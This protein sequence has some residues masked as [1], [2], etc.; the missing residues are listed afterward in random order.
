MTTTVSSHH[1]YQTAARK[2]QLNYVPLINYFG[3]HLIQTHPTCLHR[4]AMLTGPSCTFALSGSYCSSGV[5]LVI[6][7]GTSLDLDKTHF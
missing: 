4:I 6:P 3:G 2:V 5:K 7:S 1:L